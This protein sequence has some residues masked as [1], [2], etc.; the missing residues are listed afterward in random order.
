MTNLAWRR[1]NACFIQPV[2]LN[3]RAVI[4]VG[5]NSVKV[6]VADV[7]GREVRPV[8]ETSRQTRLGQGFYESRMLQAGPVADSA[9]A[10][11]D[12]ASLARES[13]A[14]TVRVIAT[15]AA[16][17]AVNPQDLIRAIE[18]VAQVTVEIIS[19][20]LEAEWAYAGVTS[21]PKLGIAP[22]LLLDVGGGSTE[23]ILGQ[24]G[25]REFSASFAVGAVR[26]LEQNPLSNPPRAGDLA[27]CL[28]EISGFL[29]SEVVPGLEPAL[30][31][32]RMGGGCS[33]LHLV[34]TGG[35]ASILARMELR[36]D[37]FDRSRIEGVRFTRAQ[38]AFHLQRL[39]SVSLEERS[40]IPGLPA[41]RADII[42][43]GVAIYQAVMDRFGMNELRVSTRGLRFAAL[44]DQPEPVRG[45]ARS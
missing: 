11:A 34:G 8:L 24:G 17:D 35:T 3:R 38:V 30:R 5:T 4:D 7:R 36:S 37:G 13:G 42:L 23:F 27:A 25:C 14:R 40:R 43:T 18:A 10:V 26:L 9:R 31:R 16:R 19:G 32:G 12:F 45:G 33:G 21:D 22:L 39:W 20:D 41:K 15:S 2:I 1:A 6:L 29:D 28:K 44:M